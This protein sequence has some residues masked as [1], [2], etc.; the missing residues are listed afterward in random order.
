VP[1]PAWLDIFRFCSIRDLGASLAV[2]KHWRTVVD[3]PYVWADA[4]DR[5]QRVDDSSSPIREGTLRSLIDRPFGEDAIGWHVAVLAEDST[6]GA[7]RYFTGHVVAFSAE[8]DTYLVAYGLGPRSTL[9]WPIGATQ[10]DCRNESVRVGDALDPVHEAPQSQT[11]WELQ[12]AQVTSAQESAQDASLVAASSEAPQPSTTVEEKNAS[13][14]LADGECGDLDP[15]RDEE[16][17]RLAASFFGKRYVGTFEARQE[18]KYCVHRR[19][20]DD[21]FFNLAGEVGSKADRLVACT[22]VTGRPVTTKSA[23]TAAPVAWSWE[24]STPLGELSVGS[25]C[26]TFPIQHHQRCRAAAAVLKKRFAGILVSLTE[27]YGCLH[28]VGDQDIMFNR[29]RTTESKSDRELV[30]S[31]EKEPEQAQREKLSHSQA[32]KLKI[33][34]FGWTVRSPK[35]ELLLPYA[36]ALFQACDGYSFFTD[37]E[38]SA[39]QTSDIV[40]VQLPKTQQKRTDSFWLLLKNMV[41]L[42]PAWGFLFEHNITNNYDW[43]VNVELDHF[44]VASL[45]RQTIADYM[46]VMIAGGLPGQD[47]WSDAVLLVF[48]NV[49]AFN[50]K[51]VQNMK[52]EWDTISQVI[53]DGGS[54][55][56]G[57]PMISGPRAHDEGRCEQDM[58]YENLREHMHSSVTIVGANGCGNTATSDILVP[59]PLACWQDFPF[60]GEEEERQKALRELE[61]LWNLPAEDAK[62]LCLSKEEEVAK[63][64][65]SLLRARH[66]PIIHNIKSPELHELA[67]KL[68]PLAA[69][70]ESL[71]EAERATGPRG[72]VD[73]V[74]QFVLVTAVLPHEAPA[75]KGL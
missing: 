41:G 19:V 23:T 62:R 64:C 56:L 10:E 25:S 17:C 26:G 75:L 58:V 34:C 52:G 8:T 12:D 49:F 50:A 74:C 31:S 18:P 13:F 60:G 15:V 65:K 7:E 1:N 11:T 14:V 40:K 47:P 68:L 59:F 21:L 63:H 37:S 29:V 70:A 46:N 4:Y 39:E 16:E 54:K 33:Y 61:P 22:D 66:V 48:G 24:L 28:R 3:S 38:N 72:G 27:P 43:V 20:D 6:D 36:R 69:K 57:C 67:L 51:L 71:G 32:A 5:T 73:H 42:L 30:C 35:E 44:F 9:L 45:L 2:D 53:T 55:G